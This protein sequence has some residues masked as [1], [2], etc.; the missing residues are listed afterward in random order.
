MLTGNETKAMQSALDDADEQW[1]NV[2][3]QFRPRA[4]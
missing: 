4:I 1:K 2:S 3:V